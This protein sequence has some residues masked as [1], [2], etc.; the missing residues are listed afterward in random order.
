MEATSHPGMEYLLTPALVDAARSFNLVPT[1][2]LST[3]EAGSA[4]IAEVERPRATPE[5]MSAQG[6][7]RAGSASLDNT[8]SGEAQEAVA[9]AAAAERLATAA[10]AKAL[11]VAVGLAPSEGAAEDPRHV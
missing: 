11:A 7:P 6:T 3:V 2:P 1:G 10:K 5:R 4:S 8:A 9:F